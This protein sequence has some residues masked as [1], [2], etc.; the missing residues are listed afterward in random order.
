MIEI[1]IDKIENI[2]GTCGGL[3][4]QHW[5]EVAHNKD[6]IK[7]A[8]DRKKYISLEE[9]GA[10]V[11]F[12]AFNGDERVGYSIFFVSPHLHYSNNIFAMN[13]VVFVSKEYRR[14]SVGL[15]L[16]KFAEEYL[17]SIGA[18]IISYH[19]KPDHDAKGLFSRLGYNM[20]ELTYSKCLVK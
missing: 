7:L 3:F 20:A 10:L 18:S 11:C 4:Q 14:G 2:L 13:D 5:E 16:M 19:F 8:I 6:K 1:K 17:E 12:S 9:V 15:R